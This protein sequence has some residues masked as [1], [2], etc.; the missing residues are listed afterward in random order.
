MY[1]CPY[2][3]VEVEFATIQI[4]HLEPNETFAVDHGSQ[5]S[6]VVIGS[7]FPSYNVFDYTKDANP[8]GV[9]E[10][11]RL[12]GFRVPGTLTLHTVSGTEGVADVSVACQVRVDDEEEG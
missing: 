10:T 6:Q 5:T 8:D 4:P 3:D 9:S 2:I 7:T 11:G 1:V 12:T